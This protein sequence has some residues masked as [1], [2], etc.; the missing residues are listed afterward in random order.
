MDNY[1][2]LIWEKENTRKARKYFLYST[3]HLWVKTEFR[4]TIV[5]NDFSKFSGSCIK[6][7]NFEKK[8]TPL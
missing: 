2:L 7:L 3:L 6:C 5:M 8:I 4:A 1:V